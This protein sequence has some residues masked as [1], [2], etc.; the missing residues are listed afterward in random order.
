MNLASIHADNEPEPT[1][2]NLGIV[3]RCFTPV[4]VV[5]G[6]GKVEIEARELVSYDSRIIQ[7]FVLAKVTPG[8][9]YAQEQSAV[10]N[11]DDLEKVDKAI[12][13][14]LATNPDSTKFKQIEVEFG[15]ETGFKLIVFNDQKGKLMAAVCAGNAT[16]HF[17]DLIK[18]TEVRALLSKAKMIIDTNRST[19]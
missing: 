9:E 7:Y 15:I 5:S 1:A 17:G 3:I 18:L 2:D 12:E 19:S 6:W 16:M 4:G 14:L 11:Y 10:I 8:G 13:R